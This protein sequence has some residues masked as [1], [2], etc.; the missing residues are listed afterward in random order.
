MVEYP[1][2]LLDARFLRDVPQAH[3]RR[4]VMRRGVEQ[5]GEAGRR[6]VE[7][8][9]RKRKGNGEGYVLDEVLGANAVRV[10][11]GDGEGEEGMGLW[12]EFSVSFRS[13]RDRWGARM[14]ER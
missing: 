5:L 9:D 7:G 14:G 10:P 3:H 6:G 8:L 2:L 1:A 13:Y 4:R 12:L 11:L